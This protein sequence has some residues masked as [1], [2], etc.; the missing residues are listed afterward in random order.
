M[1]TIWYMPDIE[2]TRAT[3]LPADSLWP[4][5]SAVREWGV[6]LPTVDAVRA[7]EPDRPDEVGAR[8]VV[9]QPGLPRATWTVTAWR[10]GR[11]FTWESRSPG[12]TSTG[13]HELLP[14]PGGTTI[15]LALRWRGPLAPGLRLVLGPKAARYVTHEA[16][17]LE[18]TAR[19]RAGRA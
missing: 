15:R 1:C 12:V 7:L 5:M 8:Y 10:P 19:E 17:S 2:I 14:G 16:A 6:W 4:V 18:A 13:E 9:E 3:D 11:S